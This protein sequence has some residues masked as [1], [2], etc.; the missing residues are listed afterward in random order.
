MTNLTKYSWI[1]SVIILIVG[2]LVLHFGGSSYGITFFLAFPAAVGFS[3]GTHNGKQRAYLSLIFALLVFFGF[4]LATG[5]E[6]FI[7]VLMASPIFFLMMLFG[8]LLR[9]ILIKKDLR[10]S[11]EVLVSTMPIIILLLLSPIE[12]MIIPDPEIV[13]IRNSIIL[14]YAPE[15]VFDEVKQMD[16]LD[17]KKPMGIALGLPSPYQCILE[18][19]TIGAKRYCLFENGRIIAKITNY[20]KGKILE[21]DVVDYTLTGRDWFEFVDAS[22]T[23]QIID[24]RTEI[25]RTSSYK[26]VLNPRAYWQPLEAWGIAQEHEFV[27]NSLKKNLK[28]KYGE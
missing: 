20:E 11:E 15:I 14:D 19:D 22:Y 1:T 9:R 12:D 2:F 24:N 17:A 8:Y 13:T 18:A 27:L 25:T 6:G 10:N 28:E 4:L 7:C 26:S 3:I 5:L 16:K 21:M 23:F